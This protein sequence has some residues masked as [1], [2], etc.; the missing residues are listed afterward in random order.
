LIEKSLTAFLDD[1]AAKTSAP[2]GG[3]AAAVVVAM[4]AG[5]A[6]MVARF[7]EQH[8]G[9]EADRLAARADALRAD[10]APLAAEDAAAYSAYLAARRLPE[11]EPGRATALTEAEGRSAAIPLRIAE[12]G[13]EVALLAELLAERGNSNLSGDA[14]AAKNFASAA[15]R[16]AAN[17]VLVNL[18]ED[19]DDDRARRAR[20]LLSTPA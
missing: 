18:G 14:L 9:E 2:G 3:A 17:L 20:E 6:G 13:A 4:A 15:T 11:D 5:L 10:A 1:L 8:L 16:T 12:I 19:S 7:S